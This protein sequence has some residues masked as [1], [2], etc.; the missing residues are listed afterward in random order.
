MLQKLVDEMSRW[1]EGYVD[2]VEYTYGCYGELNPLRINLAFLNAGLLPPEVATACE[3]G[4]GQGVSVNVHAAATAT[5]WYGTDFNPA[6]AGFA[7]ELAQA[8]GADLALCDEA[9]ELF[10][11]RDDLPEFDFICL[12]G[13][14]SWISDTNRDVIV[15]FIRR[16]LKVGG[17]L[18][19]SYNTHPGWAAMV[20]MRDLLVEHTSA[21]SADGAGITAKI[22]SAL[23]FAEELVAANAKFVI[24]NP[25][26]GERLKKMKEQNLNYVAHEF[27]NGIWGPMSFSKMAEW[28]EPAKVQLACP[29]NYLDAVDAVNLTTQQQS[30]L[31]GI[32]DPLFRQS[33]R[34]FC[35]NQQF[36][37]D[38]WVKGAR[39][40]SGLEQAER[41]RAQRLILS[42]ARSDVRLKVSGSLGEVDL[43]EAVY[44]PIIDILADHEIRTIGQIEQELRASG[45]GTGITFAQLSQAI[46]VLSA[47][48]TLLAAQDEAAVQ[49]AERQTKK[50]NRHLMLKAR[51]A[52]DV[53]VLASPVTGGGVPVGRFQQ[54]FLLARE[55]GQK[56]PADWAKF[57]WDIL[58]VQG[59]R[60][61]KD[62]KALETADEHLVHLTEIAE[63]FASKQLPILKALKIA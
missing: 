38:Y 57:V 54:L 46:V 28:L 5:K 63:S 44:N 35:V 62:G 50:L 31:S 47:N 23:S 17:V 61:L 34:D 59:Q 22:A 55:Q 12:H 10:C 25:Q 1:T 60:M 48:G 18:Y 20:P 53:M 58:A 40:L 6:Q 3:L 51:S 49:H 14:F 39:K 36:R 27:F 45:R 11:K 33:V 15:D 30:L 43:Q 19:I 41:L 37:R 4:F 26:I 56:D 13:I 24:A 2:E 7:Q 16:K 32:P 29:A 9:F 8:S 21:M 42:A 52:A